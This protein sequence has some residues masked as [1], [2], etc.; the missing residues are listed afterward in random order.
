[1]GT[2]RAGRDIHW[3]APADPLRLYT[4][5]YR[6]FAKCRRPFCE[7]RRE[8]HVPLL[9]IIF[10]PDTTLAEI[11]TRFRC[12]KCQLR[13]ARIESEYIGPTNDGR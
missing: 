13:G 4:K 12:F 3:G 8:L 6:L 2:R 5:H 7:H 10:E 1:M 11:G 9:L